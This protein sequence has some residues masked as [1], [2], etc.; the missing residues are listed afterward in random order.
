MAHEGALDFLL[1][2]A[3]RSNDPAVQRSI[4]SAV[5]N[6]ARIGTTVFMQR[7]LS[8]IDTAFCQPTLLESRSMTLLRSWTEAAD[9]HVRQCAAQCL[10]SLSQS[11]ELAPGLVKAGALG[12]LTALCSL[13]PSAEA[14]VLL[15]RTLANL[16][17]TPASCREMMVPDTS[18]LLT[19]LSSVAQ[20]NPEAQL[21]IA[22]AVTDLAQDDS[23]KALVVQSGWLEQ[24][25]ALSKSSSKSVRL[26]VALALLNLVQ[27][28]EIATKIMQEFGF[29][30]FTSLADI[31][32]LEV[33]RV[34]ERCLEK[35]NSAE[36]IEER[37][38]M[39]DY[40]VLPDDE[41]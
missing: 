3:A 28:D 9:G 10:F 39:D 26:H 14:G 16:T 27:A 13:A 15:A 12:M 1:T 36:S 34:V 22:K 35:L 29:P 18:R 41:A 7:V 31:N 4:A 40:C 6:F 20:A 38:Q 32:D 17:S 25:I 8:D 21:S 2:L 23:G 19:S 5:A 24:L 11:P 30:L 37:I 33:Q